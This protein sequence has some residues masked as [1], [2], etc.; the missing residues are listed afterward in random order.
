MTRIL[1]SRSLHAAPDGRR[2]RHRS[3][4]SGQYL[5]P[6]AGCEVRPCL[7]ALRV[8]V[9]VA[10]AHSVKGNVRAANLSRKSN[11]DELVEMT[12]TKEGRIE[13]VLFVVPMTLRDL[14]GTL[15][16]IVVNFSRCAIGCRVR[17]PHV[18]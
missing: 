1:S 5:L 17:K 4:V 2:E 11:V 13:L 6:N 12:G 10:V 14:L 3:F 15:I 18:P 7:D 9:V 16:V 8:P